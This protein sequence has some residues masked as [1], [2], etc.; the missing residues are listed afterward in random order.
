M[1]A[2]Y[3]AGNPIQLTLEV[4]RRNH[5]YFYDRWWQQRSALTYFKRLLP[6]AFSNL[7]VTTQ[8]TVNQTPAGASFGSQLVPLGSPSRADADALLAPYA[9]TSRPAPAAAG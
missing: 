7:L 8:P 1:V 3:Q 4:S 6:D 2:G 9:Y 5:A